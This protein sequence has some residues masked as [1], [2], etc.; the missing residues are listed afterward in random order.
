MTDLALQERKEVK[1]IHPLFMTFQHVVLLAR[2]FS[3]VCNCAVNA[4]REGD[5]RFNLMNRRAPA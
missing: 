1:A 5:W 3:C 2:F 4:E